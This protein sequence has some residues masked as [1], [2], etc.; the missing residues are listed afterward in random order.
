MKNLVER[1]TPITF[2]VDWSM[3]EKVMASLFLI[4]IF[5]VYISLGLPD[6]F[7]GLA[8][9]IMQPEFDVA[10]GNAGIISMILSA[11]TVVA[12]LFIGKLTKRFGIGKLVLICFIFAT[13]GIFGFSLASSFI[14]LVFMAIPLGLGGGAIGTSLNSYVTD[15]YESRHMNWLHSFWGVGALIGPMIISK[16]ISQYNSWRHSYLIVGIWDILI[17]ILL[18]VA[19]PYWQKVVSFKKTE[20]DIY[21]EGKIHNQ[22]EDDIGKKQSNNIN[23][24]GATKIKGVRSAMLVFFFYSGIEASIGLWGGSYLIRISGFNTTKAAFFISFYYASITVGRFLSGFMSIC[25]NNRKLIR[26]GEIIVLVGII[27]LFLPLPADLSAIS[28]VLIG[29]GC[30]PIIPCMIHETPIGFGHTHAPLIVGLQ[31]SSLYTGAMIL[32]PLLGQI[33][34][35]FSISLLPYFL[36][37]YII[38]MLIGTERIPSKK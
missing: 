29:F 36:M 23:I 1:N 4:I 2:N 20:S 9:P 8:W 7:L 22:P 19:L 30:A 3:R 38:V 27:V 34:N 18:A 12:S 25:I 6:G 15:N 24:L 11:S 28:F 21:N 5:I 33:S 17:I 37:L 35:K 10:F 31:M 32:P 14:W 16:T 26:I 13:I